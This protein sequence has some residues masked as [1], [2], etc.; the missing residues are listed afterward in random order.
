[1]KYLVLFFCLIGCTDE[2]QEKRDKLNRLNCYMSCLKSAQNS[3][4]IFGPYVNDR[5]TE[6]DANDLINYCEEKWGDFNDN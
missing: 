4:R 3:I 2:L 5:L 6:K 1:M